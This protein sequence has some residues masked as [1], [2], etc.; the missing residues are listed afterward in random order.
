VNVRAI[1][2]HARACSLFWCRRTRSL[3][4][5]RFELTTLHHA[6]G[7]RTGSRIRRMINL[8][9]RR[10]RGESASE[11]WTLGL[12]LSQVSPRSGRQSRSLR[13]S[14]RAPCP[15]QAG[16]ELVEAGHNPQRRVAPV[17]A[18]R[19]TRSVTMCSRILNG[20]LAVSAGNLPRA[21]SSITWCR[22]CDQVDPHAVIQPGSTHLTNR[23]WFRKAPGSPS[24]TEP[25]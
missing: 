17:R 25:N 16:S 7:E 19:C 3:E 9:P 23:R 14:I 18:S 5:G 15:P 6:A 8:I 10:H 13:S 12:A 24:Q 11:A 1:A 20:G 4:Q 2:V 22:R 21:L